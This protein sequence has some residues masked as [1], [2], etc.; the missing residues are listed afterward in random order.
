MKRSR[1]ILSLAIVCLVLSLMACGAGESGIKQAVIETPAGE[2]NYSAADL[3]S[4][5]SLMS[6]QGLDDMPEMKQAHITDANMRMFGAETI[7]GM[8]MSIV[9]TTNTIASAEKEMEGG[10]VQ[11]FADDIREQVP[12]AAL[13][14]LESPDIGDEAT[15]VG[16]GHPDLGLN[17][18][19]VAFRKA[20]V[21]VLFSLIG[22]ADSVT[23]ETVLDY[24]RKLEAKIQ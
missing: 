10:S 20:N 15:M 7:S 14:T 8:A 12:G 16:G 9:F 6:D 1:L 24:A 3:G 21:I 4:D 23:E 13:E 11:S 17:I 19:L 5:W 18:Y 2:I 22:S